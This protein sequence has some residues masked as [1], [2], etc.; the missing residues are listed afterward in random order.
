MWIYLLILKSRSNFYF[1]ILVEP[2]YILQSQYT[3]YVSPGN[4]WS[5]PLGTRTHHCFVMP[6]LGKSLLLITVKCRM[7]YYKT[8]IIKKKNHNIHNIQSIGTIDC[9]I[10]IACALLCFV[11]INWKLFFH[12]LPNTLF[13]W[14][15]ITVMLFR[16]FK[17]IR[18]ENRIGEDEFAEDMKQDSQCDSLT[19]F[20]FFL[21]TG[22]GK[23]CRLSM[24]KTRKVVL[25]FWNWYL[26]LLA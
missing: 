6:R 23:P 22:L 20:F 19:F 5:T 4:C 26:L 16:E 13:D 11:K 2:L 21:S 8:P 17:C 25:R 3:L 12:W 14:W 15:P 24:G 7:T 10:L 18:R 9:T 1:F